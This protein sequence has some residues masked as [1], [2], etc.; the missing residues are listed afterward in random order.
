[1]PT[2]Q[3]T[4]IDQAL[5]FFDRTRKRAAEAAN[6]L[7]EAQWHFKP[8]ANC[9]SAAEILEHMV[10][11]QERVL[12]PA[13]ALLL[14]APPPPPE[15]ETGVIDKIIMERIPDRSRKAEAPEP[16][17]PSGQWDRTTTLERLS[18]N[19]NALAEFVASTPGLRDHAVESKPL[20]FITNGAYTKIDGYQ[21]TLL[22]AAHDERHIRQILELRA[23][24]NY[25]KN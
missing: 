15:H 16:I 8:S 6:G 5:E 14:Q 18:K 22:V 21:L 17:K 12:G 24:P 11:V 23:D 4:E 3:S 13:R 9:W 7:S 10:M 19:Y 2:L 20:Q 1:M 25:P